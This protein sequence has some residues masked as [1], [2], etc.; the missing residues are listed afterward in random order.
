VYSY[1]TKIETPNELNLER[2]T[3]WR[4]EKAITRVDRPLRLARARNLGYKA[5]QGFVMVRV[6]VRRGGLRK[7]VP[8]SA[9]RPRHIG[10][11][12]YTPH[13]SMMLIAQERASKKFPNLRALNGYWVGEDG[14]SKWFEVILVDPNHPA[15]VSDKDINWIAGPNQIGRAERGLTSPGK[16][17]RGLQA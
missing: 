6:R 14:Q 10:S 11:K 4:K 9:R 3:A 2:L 16:K 5:K 12:K 17:M 1:R 8:S 13:K 15:I 7:S